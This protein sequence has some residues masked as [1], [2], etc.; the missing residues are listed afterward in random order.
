MNQDATTGSI[1]REEETLVTWLDNGRLVP[2][3]VV[4]LR[5]FMSFSSAS[6]SVS[7]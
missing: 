1:E 7:C 5:Q 6:S 3:P 2:F 4:S